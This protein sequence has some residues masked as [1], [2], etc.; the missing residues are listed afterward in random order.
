MTILC[1]IC[2]PQGIDLQ[3]FSRLWLVLA[4][5]V[6][7]SRGATGKLTRSAFAA[8]LGGRGLSQEGTGLET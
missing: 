6:A 3:A 4:T 1:T 7:T 5:M 2:T 8:N